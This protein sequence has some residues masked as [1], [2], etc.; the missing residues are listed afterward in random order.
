[1]L[2][3]NVF[4]VEYVKEEH[5]LHLASFLKWYHAISEDFKKKFAGIYLELKYAK[6]HKD[7]T[8]RLSMKGYIT[9]LL[10]WLGNSKETKSQLS[11]HK[12][13]DIVYL[14]N[15]QLRSEDKTYSQLDNDG[16]TRV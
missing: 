8:C 7:R 4:G 6:V 11:P 16:I 15:V 5:T 1:M 2:V 9:Y 10:L 3:V 13:K 14:S 12:S